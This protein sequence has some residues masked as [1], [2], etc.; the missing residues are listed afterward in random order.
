MLAVVVIQ[1]PIDKVGHT[2]LKS[3]VDQIFQIGVKMV[4]GYL[5]F[6]KADFTY[7]DVAVT[8]I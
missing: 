3:R 6:L 5:V 7:I 1:F 2:P 8:E 4:V